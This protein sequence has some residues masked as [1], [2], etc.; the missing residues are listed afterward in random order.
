MAPDLIRNR[1][2]ETEIVRPPSVEFLNRTEKEQASYLSS[3][4][5]RVR[6]P[7]S[8]LAT[9]GAPLAIHWQAQASPVMESFP[10]FTILTLRSGRPGPGSF[11]SLSEAD[12]CGLCVGLQVQVHFFPPSFLFSLSFPSFF[13]SL[14]ALFFKRE[15]CGDGQRIER[16]YSLRK[17][18]LVA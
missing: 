16:N 1:N 5:P 10:H 18:S 4:S 15:N 17:T 12:P 9:P 14:F 13:L 7:S 11:L 8:S 2:I 3:L 6:E